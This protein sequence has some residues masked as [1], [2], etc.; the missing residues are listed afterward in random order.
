VGLPEALFGCAAHR[1]RRGEASFAA[2]AA[3]AGLLEYE[4]ATDAGVRGFEEEQG[5]IYVPTTAD[6]RR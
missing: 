5:R 6:A 2:I 3:E 4:K 1:P